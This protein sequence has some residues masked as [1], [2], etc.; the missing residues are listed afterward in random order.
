MFLHQNDVNDI[1]IS[2]VVRLL[3]AELLAMNLIEERY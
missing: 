2:P 3:D 1:N